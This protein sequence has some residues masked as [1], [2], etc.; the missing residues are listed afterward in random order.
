MVLAGER[1]T[2]GVVPTTPFRMRVSGRANV[3]DTISVRCRLFLAGMRAWRLA[4][5]GEAGHSAKTGESHV[6]RHGHE[7]RSLPPKR[8]GARDN[9]RLRTDVISSVGTSFNENSCLVWGLFGLC[10]GWEGSKKIDGMAAI[11]EPGRLRSSRGLRQCGARN[12]RGTMRTARG[13]YRNGHTTGR[14]VFRDRSRARSRSLHLI[15]GLY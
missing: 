13:F 3:G 15:Q 1:F 5:H 11:P 8:A 10:F 7:K 2:E 6:E 12:I 9:S 14:A 4:T